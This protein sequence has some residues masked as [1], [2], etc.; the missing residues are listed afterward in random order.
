MSVHCGLNYFMT[1]QI[2]LSVIEVGLS[3]IAERA[4]Q[5]YEQ[6]EILESCYFK[7]ADM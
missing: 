1:L 4:E 6:I 3:G 2:S 7:A 5:C